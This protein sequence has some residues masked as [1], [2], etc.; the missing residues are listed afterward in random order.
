MQRNRA[1]SGGHGK[2]SRGRQY[3]EPHPSNVAKVRQPGSGGSAN[4]GIQGPVRSGVKLRA[5]DAAR[6]AATIGHGL[7]DYDRE[8][9]G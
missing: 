9:F 5:A 2:E 6:K 7:T 3:K 8:N 4:Q 1:E